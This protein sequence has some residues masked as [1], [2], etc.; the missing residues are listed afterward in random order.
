[1]EVAPDPRNIILYD[2]YKNTTIAYSSNTTG[3]LGPPQYVIIDRKWIKW[4]GARE[5]L[6]RYDDISWNSYPFQRIGESDN[7]S[8]LAVDESGDIWV[9][10]DDGLHGLGLWRFH[11]PV[12]TNINENASLPKSLKITGNHPNPFNP[13][14]TISFT[15]SSP[16]QAELDVYSSTGQKVCTLISGNQTAGTHSVVWDGRDDSRKAVSSGVYL[17]RLQMGDKVA[18]GRMLLLK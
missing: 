1:M 14:T 15:L 11:P 18:F 4:F 12:I 9:G 2:R 7:I 16:G 6:I 10:R 3:V 8:S 13:S 5:S 17:S